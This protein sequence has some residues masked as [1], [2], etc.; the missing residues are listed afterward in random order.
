MDF[1]PAKE[2]DTSCLLDK[3]VIIS[4]LTCCATTAEKA[5]RA[6]GPY[7]NSRRNAL[8]YWERL[9][10][11]TTLVALC[12]RLA[13]RR[14]LTDLGVLVMHGENGGLPAHCLDVDAFPVYCLNSASSLPK[15]VKQI[16]W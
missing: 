11:V 14:L 6:A 4:C 2:N 12:R 5:F 9:T 16:Y 7:D 13:E 1:P 15:Q 10:D 3:N 8:P